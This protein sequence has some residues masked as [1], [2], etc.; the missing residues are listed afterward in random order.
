MPIFCWVAAIVAWWL[1]SLSMPEAF[2]SLG[3]VIP[4]RNRTCD[5]RNFLEQRRHPPRLRI[6]RCGDPGDPDRYGD[7]CAAA[8]ICRGWAE[9][10]GRRSC[11]LLQLVPWDRLG[12]SWHRLVRCPHGRAVMIVQISHHFC[13]LLLV[14]VGGGCQEAIGTEEVEMGAVLQPPPLGGILADRISDA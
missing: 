2:P 3:S 13:R 5:Q 10:R 6:A 1:T 8:A 14:N 4:R 7:R 9:N 11:A 12:H